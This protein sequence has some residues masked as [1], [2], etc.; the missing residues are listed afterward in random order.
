MEARPG[1]FEVGAAR[2]F[3]ASEAGVLAGGP[4]R[5][6]WCPVEGSNLH[7]PLTRRLHGH[8]AD[9]AT[10]QNWGD[11]AV[12]IRSRGRFTAGRVRLLPHVTIIVVLE[13]GRGIE[14]R[15]R[16]LQLRARPTWLTP[17]VT[18]ST[19]TGGAELNSPSRVWSPRRSPEHA[20]KCPG[21]DAPRVNGWQ[22]RD[23][24]ELVPP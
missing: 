1:W 13:W 24:T 11:V 21:V 18:R 10:D 20:G 7:R 15:S 5:R 3:P 17:H 9:R 19:G 23:R 22:P 4:T 8:R 14:P 2:G 6:R 12:S 16:R